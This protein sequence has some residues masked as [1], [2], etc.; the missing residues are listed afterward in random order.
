MISLI[1]FHAIVLE[2]VVVW[3]AVV[4]FPLPRSSKDP[5]DGEYKEHIFH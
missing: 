2:D 3:G 4:G 1:L 5:S